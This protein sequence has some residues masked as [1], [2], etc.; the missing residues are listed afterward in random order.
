[1]PALYLED[2]PTMA[3]FSFDHEAD[4]WGVLINPDKS[5]SPLLEQLCLGIAHMIV[6]WTLE[7]KAV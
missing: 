3:S 7:N 1:M 5:P 2:R 6:S 4:F